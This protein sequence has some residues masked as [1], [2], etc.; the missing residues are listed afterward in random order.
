MYLDKEKINFDDTFKYGKKIVGKYLIA[1]VRENNSNYIKS[2]VITSK[3]VGNAVER[4]RI[5]RI[6]REAVININKNENY[7]IDLI[8]ISKHSNGNNNSLKTIDMIKD[9]NYILRRR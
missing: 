2:G 9:I 3:K 6:V 1:Y 4:N 5:K 8:L 7:N